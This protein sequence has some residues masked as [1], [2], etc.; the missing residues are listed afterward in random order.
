[1]T[2]G[3]VPVK[4]FGRA[5]SR[6]PLAP[7]TR[8]TLAR[9]MMEHVVGT[10]ASL[11][12]HV[13]VVT[14]CAEVAGIAAQLGARPLFDAKD[15][16]GEVIDQAIAELQASRVLVVMSDLPWLAR[17][18]LEEMLSLGADVVAAPDEEGEG[19]NALLLAR[20]M[21]TCF[22]RRGSFAMHCARAHALG[23]SLSIVRRDGLMRDLDVSPPSGA[24]SD[25]ARP[26]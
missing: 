9:S 11:L 13:A 3:L 10:L 21:P 15:Q 6:L 24:C 16:L 5:K 22:G 1:V 2:W 14:N 17:A 4:G 8:A 23:L 18:D 26:A 25:S 20:P 7:E 12:P 19:T